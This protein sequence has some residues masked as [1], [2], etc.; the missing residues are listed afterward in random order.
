MLARDVQELDTRASD[1]VQ[2]ASFGSGAVR[3]DATAL[4]TVLHRKIVS[5]EAMAA[6]VEEATRLVVGY[7]TG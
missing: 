4:V 6:L 1:G 5:D 7:L 2:G 3:V